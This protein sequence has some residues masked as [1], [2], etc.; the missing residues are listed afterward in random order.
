MVDELLDPDVVPVLVDV[1]DVP[2]ELHAAAAARTSAAGTA[3]RTARRVR[4]TWRIGVLP[5]P[6]SAVT[7]AAEDEVPSLPPCHGPD[8]AAVHEEFRPRH[9]DGARL[10]G[11]GR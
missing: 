1:V 4:T 9:L 10:V 3:N 6:W 11:F 7:T 8:P 2:E 5:F